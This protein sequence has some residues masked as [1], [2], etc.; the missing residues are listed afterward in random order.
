M[1]TAEVISLLTLIVGI[2]AIIIAIIQIRVSKPPKKDLQCIWVSKVPLVT[3]RE[4][5]EEHLQILWKGKLLKDATS[6]ILR[7]QNSGSLA[8][9]S[10]DFERPISFIFTSNTEIEIIEPK[11]LKTHP[12]NLGAVISLNNNSIELQP[13]LMNPGD[14]IDIAAI[15][16]TSNHNIVL[17]GRVINVKN[18]KLKNRIED[19][20]KKEKMRNSILIF[21][22][23]VLSF[24]TLLNVFLM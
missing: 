19:E 20:Y 14:K 21:I 7:I 23:L 9:T 11:I 10:Q 4:G 12:I 17:N 15:V 6:I 22:L 3:V 16:N 24:M 1:T 5:Y 18:L 2:I 8:I 13:L